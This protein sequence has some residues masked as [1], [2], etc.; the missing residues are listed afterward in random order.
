MFNNF[1]K[2]EKFAR[3]NSEK[4]FK[5][6]GYKISMSADDNKEKHWFQEYMEKNP[7]DLDGIRREIEEFVGKNKKNE[8]QVPI[9]KCYQN[10][11]REKKKRKKK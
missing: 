4:N 11:E 7:I 9:E 5:S 3:L 6:V 8:D 10:E 1:E 2:L